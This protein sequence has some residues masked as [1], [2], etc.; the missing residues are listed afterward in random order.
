MTFVCSVRLA[1]FFQQAGN[2]TG[3]GQVSGRV[4]VEGANTP[5]AAARGLLVPAAP[6]NGLM[7]MPPETFTGT[8]GR[9]T[10]ATVAP[11]EYR[12]DIRKSGFAPLMDPTTR[13]PSFTLA[14]GQSVDNIE[15][16][17]EKG[18]VIAGRVMD[19]NGEPLTD[20][21]IMVMRR[22]LPGR[23]ERMQMFPVPVQG[24]HQTN[25]LG[26]FRIS[27]LRAAEYFVAATTRGVS[28]F[29]G[30][31][32]VPAAA[33]S[34]R[35]TT[36]TTF[37]PGTVDQNTAQPVNVTAGAETGNIVFTMQSMPAFQ[38]SGVVVDES[39]APVAQAM[40]MLTGDPRNGPF[41]PMGQGLSQDDGRFIISDVPPGTYRFAGSIPIRMRE[42]TSSG[43]PVIGGVRLRRR[44]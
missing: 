31:R 13:R 27:G 23:S 41:G 36:V 19:V 44:L 6:T 4:A 33:G 3:A 24:P 40:V 38:I 11:G 26:E 15:I 43:T 16:L 12:I 25:D 32:T 35:T 5:I 1:L 37:Y 7:R 30:A 42:G 8:D 2:P 29:G 22:N 28:A 18:G 20:A 34:L 21:H 17:L 39:G 14:S 10:F 9:F